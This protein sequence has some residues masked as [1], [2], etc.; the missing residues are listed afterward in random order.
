MLVVVLGVLSRLWTSS[1]LWL[2]ESLSLGI[3]SLPLEEGYQALRRDG[4]PPAYYL[5]LHGWIALFGTGEVAVRSLSVLTSLAALPLVWVAGR[6]LGGRP[7]AA[8]ALLLLAVSPFAVRYATET[9]M[10]ALVQLLT[11]AGA[12]LLLRALERPSP[13]RLAPVS[14][15]A[16]VLA[17]THYWA[18]F[19]LAATGLLLLALAV[20]GPDRRAGRRTLLALCAGGLLFLP[21]LPTFAFQATRTGTPWAADPALADAF[22]TG[23][24]WTGGPTGPG[25]LLLIGLLGLGLLGLVGRRNEAGVL[26]SRPVR[27]TA[28]ALLWLSLGTL[29]LG[30]LAGM[31]ADAGY[32]ARYSSVAVVPA[33]L[34]AAVG[35]TALAPRARHVL[36]AVLAVCGLAGSVFQPFSDSRTQAGLT[37]QTLTRL[38]QP[39]DLV[40][41]C[42]DQLGPAVSR[43]LPPGTDQ[44][45]YPTMDSPVLV[46]WVDY[47]ARNSGGSPEA[48]AREASLRADGAVWLVWNEGYRTFGEQCQRLD[49]DLT[50]ARGGRRQLADL[51]PGYGEQQMLVRYPET[52]AAR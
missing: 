26:L 36:L 50:E 45:V 30:L 21:W 51:E 46:D 8:A 31:V 23:Q 29:L 48:F 52:A 11:A 5:V 19:L 34:L 13:A 14:L 22:A 10:Y 9:R 28:V 16:G 47:A 33:L 7:A 27:G 38:L 1:E 17:L 35:T 4:S 20:R 24:T 18:L 40:V 12:V 2:D 3:A 44:A 49:E 43:L 32:A 39:G 37:A 6:R 15:A 42:P 25:T 41:Y